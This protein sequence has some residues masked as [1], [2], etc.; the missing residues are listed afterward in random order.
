MF[1]T[2]HSVLNINFVLKRND[3]AYFIDY[4]IPSG[5]LVCMSWVSF[6]FAPDSLPAR[7]TL[8]RTLNTYISLCT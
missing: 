5:L 1:Q 6:W 7:T 4:Y 3:G 8:G 2:K